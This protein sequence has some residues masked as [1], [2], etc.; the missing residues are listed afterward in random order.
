MYPTQSFLKGTQPVGKVQYAKCS[1]VTTHS[2]PRT[3]QW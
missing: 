1:I 3:T 2:F